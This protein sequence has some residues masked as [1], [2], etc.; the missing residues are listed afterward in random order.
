LQFSRFGGFTQNETSTARCGNTIVVGFNDTG[1]F[2]ATGSDQHVG[3]SLSGWAQSVNGGSSFTDRQF[4]PPGS[5]VANVLAGS[6]VVV[7]GD[8]STFY[9]SQL[10]VT[11][12]SNGNAQ[13]G[14]AVSISKDSGASFADPAPAVLKDGSKHSID[15]SWMAVD[16]SNPKHLVIS[17]TDIDAS[18][19][20]CADSIRTAIETVESR[21]GGQS[22]SNSKV[23][24]F[25]CSNADV[26]Q[27]SHVVVGSGGATYFS[28]I[29]GHNFPTGYRELRFAS[30]A[31]GVPS[32]PIAISR[33]IPSGDSFFMKG[34]FRNA[35]GSTSLTV[36]PSG[37]ASDGTLYV[38]W[39]DGRNKSVPDEVGLDGQY[40]SA[41]ILVSS[42]TDGGR[43]WFSPLK[44]NSD[45]QPTTGGGHDH[46]QPAIV[47][48]KTG[49]VASCWYDR[50]R[51]P[52]NFMFE[53][54][55]GL[56]RDRGRSWSN[57]RLHVP[58][59]SPVTGVDAL[60]PVEYMGE[61][62]TL[63]TDSLHQ[64]PGFVGSFQVMDSRA[65]PDV[66]FTEL[67]PSH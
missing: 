20:L 24:D 8:R 4:V 21:D 59:S 34:G 63:A 33:I 29:F 66:V 31:N 12:D 1:S 35:S 14:V 23:L 46:Y 6:P 27:G 42:S 60:L 9:Y 49:A 38:V 39:D 56:S 58:A 18:H 28:W 53:R 40:A 5:N 7:C 52:E 67:Q 50:R 13:S 17:Y 43:S 30:M 51:D 47:V 10:F 22:W 32:R 37:T 16:P 19:E 61:Y 2:F 36:D 44:I 25:V 65:N 64:V 57:F 62:D 48:D 55:C 15:R 26:V 54:W 45:V 11:A 3:I 41:D